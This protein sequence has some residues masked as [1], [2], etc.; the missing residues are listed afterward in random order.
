MTCTDCNAARE[1]L[2]A[3]R[4]Y[5]PVC[6]HCG[7]RLIQA[8]GKLPL[9]PSHIKQR[10]QAVLADWKALGHDEAELRALVAGPPA[11]APVTRG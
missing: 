8:I 6:I 2:G 1:S 10:R 7:A 9:M 4:M 3:W 11:Y 5:D